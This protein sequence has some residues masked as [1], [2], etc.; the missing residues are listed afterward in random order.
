MALI[1]E[2]LCDATRMI[3]AGEPLVFSAAWR[4]LWISSL[5][6]ALATLLGLP[7]GIWLARTRFPGNRLVVLAVRVGMALPTVFVGMVCYALFSRRGPLGAFE[8]LYTPWGIVIG[9]LALALP[10]VVGISHGAIKSLD[11]RIAE[12]AWTLGA[13]PLRRWW[14]YVSEA[15]VS[16]ML[17]IL[18]AFARCVTELGIAMI[19]GGN[20]KYR[21]R[22]LA[23]ATALETS[24]G[25]FA[26][27]IALGSLLLVIS[28][29]VMALIG[30]LSRED[31]R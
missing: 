17:A 21:T 19:V 11:A 5:A 6:V 7:L 23:T 22:T 3:L 26:R 13:G 12:T 30:W 9:E 2:G 15:R 24:R 27:G 16:V 10:I 8:L 31:Q 1:W 28:L 29:A 4:S 18:T 14:T 25:E 20:I